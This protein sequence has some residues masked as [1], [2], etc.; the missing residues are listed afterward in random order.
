M[1]DERPCCGNCAWGG[2]ID[3]DG[4]IECRRYPPEVFVVD[5]TPVQ[6]APRVPPKHV[7]GEHTDPE[8]L[9]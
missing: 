4:M 6:H 5:G 1:V 3:E 9:A 8:V 7:C 2:I